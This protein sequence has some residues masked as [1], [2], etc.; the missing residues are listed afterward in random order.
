M[1]IKEKLE[2]LRK[3][4]SDKRH[5]DQQ[6]Y[7]IAPSSTESGRRCYCLAGGLN[8]VVGRDLCANIPTA[9]LLALG[10]YD[11]HAEESNNTLF[12]WNDSHDRTIKDVRTRIDEA[13]AQLKKKNKVFSV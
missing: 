4:F 7:T 2:A 12:E 3:L 6:S 13:L 5:W 9:E 10:F 1:T 8:K 11:E